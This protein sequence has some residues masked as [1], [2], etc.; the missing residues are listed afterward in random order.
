MLSRFGLPPGRGGRVPIRLALFLGCLA[1]A[2]PAPAARTALRVYTPSDGVPQA[3]VTAV[4]Q[5]RDGYL[6]VGTLT[7]GVGRYDGRRWLVED[8]SSGL[9][10]STIQALVRLPGGG[11]ATATNGGVAVGGVGGWKTLRVAPDGQG[12]SV[13]ALAVSPD[14]HLA[15]GTSAGLAFLDVGGG[16]P[17][18]VPLAKPELA[19]AEV[20][21]LAFAR[22][23]T[24]WAGTTKGVATLATGPG[25]DLRPVAG[26]PAKAIPA[27]AVSSSAHVAA[28][29]SG[30]GLYVLEPGGVPRRVGDAAMPGGRVISLAWEADARG[31]W[32]G[33]RDRGAFRWDGKRFEPLGA[34]QGLDEPR[35]WAICEDREGIVWLGT[36]SGLVKK[37]PSA[38]VTLGAAEGLPPRIPSTAW[39]SR[40]TGRSGSLLTTAA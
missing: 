39:C 12:P 1:S 15:A 21:S 20:L 3:Q 32:G 18:V 19:G 5:D 16:P 34:A 25:A 9:P 4:C 7:G 38:F 24:L 14:G 2:Q 40:P 13:W 31:L 33:T 37:G 29:V 30:E 10:G 36:D 23:G 6:W 17:R 26:I 35:V 8:A 28:A 27:I 22:D 11:I